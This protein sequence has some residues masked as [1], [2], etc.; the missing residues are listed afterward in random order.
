MK[1]ILLLLEGL[2]RGPIILL[3]G[4]DRFAIFI[5]KRAPLLF[6][7]STQFFKEASLFRRLF[8]RLS[9]LSIPYP[10]RTGLLRR[11][12]LKSTVAMT[13]ILIF[14][15]YSYAFNLIEDTPPPVNSALLEPI[16]LPGIP[17]DS[18]ALLSSPPPPSTPSQAPSIASPTYID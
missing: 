9:A 14:S 10:L 11:P 12:M 18:I 4:L 3:E 2:L 6:T 17:E 15:L 8:S 7:R 1:N 13:V 16:E 5:E